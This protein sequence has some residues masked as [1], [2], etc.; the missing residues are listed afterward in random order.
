MAKQVEKIASKDVGAVPAEV[1]DTRTTS[2]KASGKALTI[3]QGNDITLGDGRVL[4][5]KKRVTLPQLKQRDGQ[6]VAFTVLAPY[7]LAKE[8]K[9]KDDT[10]KPE[11]PPHLVHVRELE[12]GIEYHYI[13]GAVLKTAWDEEYSNGAYVNRTFAVRM[14]GKAEGKRHKDYDV[15]EIELEA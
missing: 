14:I 6:I 15:A 12:T 9:P 1:L 11:K 13:V 4:K 2:E 3:I 7:F 10:T 5:V 8:V